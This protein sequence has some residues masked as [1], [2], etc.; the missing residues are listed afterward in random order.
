MEFRATVV[1]GGKTATG[2]PVPDE[3]VAQF[4][5]FEQMPIDAAAYGKRNP[6]ALELLTEVGY[7]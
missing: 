7:E 2:I 1:L 5:D 4:G 3:V 6:E